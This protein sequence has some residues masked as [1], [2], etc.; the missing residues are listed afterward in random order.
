MATRHSNIK[1]ICLAIS[2]KAQGEIIFFTI[3]KKSFLQPLSVAQECFF[4]KVQGHNCIKWMQTEIFRVYL[5]GFSTSALFSLL[6]SVYLLALL[7]VSFSNKHRTSMAIATL[8]HHHHH[9]N[10]HPPYFPLY[11]MQFKLQL[12]QLVYN[13]SCLLCLS[14]CLYI[15]VQ[16]YNS[17]FAR[18]KKVLTKSSC[19][20]IDYL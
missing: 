9:P 20:P 19:L 11:L 5:E 18:S 3:T 8:T 12:N 2:H 17:F 6:C 14:P 13:Y 10:M 15:G 4:H 1:F 7:F 16:S